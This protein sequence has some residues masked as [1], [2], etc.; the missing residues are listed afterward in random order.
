MKTIR[1]LLTALVVWILGVGVFITSHFVPLMDEVELQANIALSI[2]LI[3]LGWLGSRSFYSKYKGP[4]GY[5]FG[6]IM[7]LTAVLMVGLI[8]VPLLVEPAGGTYSEFFSATS[9]WLIALEYYLVIVLY[10]FVRV[11]PISINS[12]S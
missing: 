1:A 4:N 5:I 8:T 6:L 12:Y 9:F 2:S 11:K 7:V 3:P 10:W